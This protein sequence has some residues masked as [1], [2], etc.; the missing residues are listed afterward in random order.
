LKNLNLENLNKRNVKKKEV[1]IRDFNLKE[2]GIKFF[3]KL[4]ER[5]SKLELKHKRNKEFEINMLKIRDLMFLKK[6][7]KLKKKFSYAKVF[8]KS[9]KLIRD[10]L[11]LTKYFY[12]LRNN[13]LVFKN[14]RLCSYYKFLINSKSK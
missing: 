4:N 1:I 3:R 6:L 5:L 9:F 8:K 12:Y 11:F 13:N 14:F 10:S 7:N 2:L